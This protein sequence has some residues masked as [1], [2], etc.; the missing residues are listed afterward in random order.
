MTTLTLIAER[1]NSL[2]GSWYVEGD[3]VRGEGTLAVVAVTHGDEVTGHLD[4]GVVLDVDRPEVPIIWDCA[5]GLGATA[6]AATER[7]IE[8]WAQTT[9]SAV[10]ELLTQRGDFAQ[11]YGAD[12]PQGL[13]GWHAIHGPILGWGKG[14]NAPDLQRWWIDNPILPLL[15]EEL[16]ASLDRPELNGVKIFFGSDAMGSTAEVRINGQRAEATSAALLG[17]G[18]PRFAEP[19]YVRSYVLLVHS[20]E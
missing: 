7:A 10:I 20:V 19:A 2:H 18:W 14:S 13:A 11:H 17:L 8:T 15:T 16:L 12:D 6:Q 5:A 1:L 9:A 4:L 3:R